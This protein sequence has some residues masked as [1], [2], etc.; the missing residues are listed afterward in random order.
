MRYRYS[1]TGRWKNNNGPRCK[2]N[3]DH[4]HWKSQYHVSVQAAVTSPPTDQVFF[5]SPLQLLLCD[6]P[7][8]D[9]FSSSTGYH[10]SLSLPVPVG[11]YSLPYAATDSSFGRLPTT[12]FVALELSLPTN[13]TCSL[14]SLKSLPGLPRHQTHH[15]SFIPADWS[16]AEELRKPAVQI[17]LVNKSC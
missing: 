10:S 12:N 16:F 8:L 13:Q 5:Y 2:N 6:I 1:S 9:L 3:H 11:L 15:L 4:R 14:L 7:Y 17:V